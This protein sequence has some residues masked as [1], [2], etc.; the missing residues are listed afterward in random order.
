MAG[1]ALA[2][3]QA[4][5]PGLTIAEADLAADAATLVRMAEWCRGVTPLVA[6]D[7]A[8]G[9]W[10]DVTGCAHLFGGEA[11]L[12]EY[13][14]GRLEGKGLHLRA[15]LA[16]TPGAAHA[17]ARFACFPLSRLRERAGVR[18]PPAQIRFVAPSPSPLSQV[19][20]G[21]TFLTAPGQ[22]M[23]A[24]D[25][26]P[27]RA[28][29]L[30]SDTVATLQR[31]GFERIGDL[32]RVPRA[33]LARR[34]GLQLGQ[35]LDQAEG[36]V[37]EPIVPLAAPE[38]LQHRVTFVEPLLTPEGL[39]LAI[40]HLVTPLCARMEQTGLGARQLDLL[41]E[42]VDGATQAIR[43]GTA[44]P[45]RAAPRLIR[46]LVE[47]LEAVDPGLGVEAMRLVAPLVEP[48]RW[49]QLDE[50]ASDV[51]ELVDRLSNRLGPACVYRQEPVESDV[52]ERSVR[53]VPALSP[54]SGGGWTGVRP[55]RLFAR[56]RLVEVLA[57]L[58]D[59]PPVAFT[60]AG[61]R[62]RVVRADGPER[63]HGEWWCRDAETDAVRDY[64]QVE[65]EEGRRFWLYRQGDGV[66]PKTGGLNWYLHGLF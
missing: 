56:P 27:L 23:A 8:D 34:L 39:A 36:R 13:L 20:E 58:P 22:H 63:V 35:R 3:A 33:S 11:G 1:M 15:A 6:V 32:G 40:Q 41:F 62:H 2:H 43:V 51:S 37:L 52:P 30:P 65:N 59:Q 57:L 19:G 4:L 50:N 60:W 16:D 49:T 17:L 14:A 12:L 64:F 61:R 66:D 10:L 31:L 26:L 47:R 45:S 28:L 44:R 38:L 54:R 21:F 42:R 46:L 24:L 7:G 29:R 5:V 25:P 9:L 53:R 48:L 18:G 55:T